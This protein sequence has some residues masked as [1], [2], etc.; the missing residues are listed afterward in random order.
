MY[1]YSALNRNLR[2]P[3]PSRDAVLRRLILQRLRLRRR[4]LLTFVLSFS[5]SFSFPSQLTLVERS[6]YFCVCVNFKGI[7]HSRCRRSRR[8]FWSSSSWYVRA[9][10]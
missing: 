5:I 9:K 4:I 6:L 2:A 10:Q 1:S 3:L 8:F 7:E